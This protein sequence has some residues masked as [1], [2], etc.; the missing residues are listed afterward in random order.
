MAQSIVV[1]VDNVI[2]VAVFGEVTDVD[3]EQLMMTVIDLLRSIIVRA[4]VPSVITLI[5]TSSEVLVERPV[6]YL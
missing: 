4:V 5:T 3:V 2:A 1:V 6:T